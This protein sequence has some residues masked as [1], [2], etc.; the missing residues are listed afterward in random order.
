VTQQVVTSAA[1]LLIGDELLSGKVRDRNLHALAMT[2]RSLGIELRRVSVVRDDVDA[3]AQEV[4]ELS[5][6]HDVARAF[7]VSTTVDPLTRRKLQE[8]YGTRCEDVQLRMATVPE[9]AT[10]AVPAEGDW[11]TVVMRNV[12]I[13][14]GVPEIFR[15]K[16]DCVRQQLRGPAPF[17]SRA[18]LTRLEEPE[19]VPLL[20]R[21]VARYTAVS[22]GSYPNWSGT[23]YRTKVTFDAHDPASVEAAL[24]AFVAL[25]PAGEP[26][27]V[28]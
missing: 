28:E 21:T 10:L 7:G 2:L 27:A 16:L 18:V 8:A 20:E 22:I 13:L 26:V 19:L 5:R 23:R 3:I 12:W 25:L 6:S 24:D 14:P 17:F 15:T 9:G 4:A 1:A 11:P